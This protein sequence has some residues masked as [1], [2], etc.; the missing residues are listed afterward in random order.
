MAKPSN[1]WDKRALRRLTEAEK[2]G[3]VYSKRIQ[4][5]YEQAQKN[6]Q[7]D[8]ENIYAN[9]SKATGM[10]VQSLKTL[11]TKTQTQKLWDELKA[12]GLDQYVKGNYKARITRLEQ[13]QA[14]LYAKVKEIYP[15]EQNEHT[16]CF[17]DVLNNTY[18]KS[19]YDTQMGT[20]YDFAFSNLDD[21]LVKSVLSERWSGKNYSQRIWGNTDIL[22][23]SVS[24]IVGGAL[25]SGQSYAKTSRQIRER[26]NVGKYYADRLVRTECNHFHNQADAMAYE[27]MGVDKYVFMAV[28][29]SRT[30]DICQRLDNKVIDLK[31]KK[32][33]VNFPPLH[34]NCRSTTRVYMGEEIEKTLKRRA[35]NPFTGEN[36]IVDN[37]SYEDWAKKYG[38]DQ[39]EQSKKLTN[40]FKGSI[41]NKSEIQQRLKKAG[42]K[43]RK[44]HKHK[45][46]PTESQIIDRLGGYDETSGSCSSLAFAYAGNKNGLDVLDFR[47]GRSCTYFGTTRNI[48]KI[49]RL[50]NVKS[51]YVKGYDDYV[52]T[53][54]LLK[55]AVDGKEYYLATGEHCAIVRKLN[56]VYEYLELQMPGNNG[57]KR[58]DVQVLADRF[59]CQ[60]SYTANGE[61][62]EVDNV[63]ID[64]SSL[65][66][67]KEF[68]KILGYINTAT[69]EQLKGGG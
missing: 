54:N 22:A 68:E 42:V 60:H 14:Q 66:G 69:K 39:L 47:G 2:Q 57:F 25:L 36:E 21:N 6:I 16:E 48:V 17:S 13:L 34:P 29:D 63:L 53:V 7:R 12:K 59:N 58:L 31:D 18:Y 61:K 28:L 51:F 10:D 49:S 62:Y 20:G 4:K 55:N 40:D 27:E 35:R 9:Y 52:S 64:I 24:E 5:I 50:P 46:Q 67:N 11:L 8:I 1:Y 38:L 3:E 41:I 26:F 19:I 33:G 15:Q 37:I 32:E 23:E 65:K 30:S 43:Y 56:G 44:V 45:T